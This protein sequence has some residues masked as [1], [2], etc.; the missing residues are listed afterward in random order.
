MAS[1]FRHRPKRISR[2]HERDR[3]AAWLVPLSYLAAAVGT[4]LAVWGAVHYSVA[5]EV[6]VLLVALSATLLIFPGGVL[7][8][9]W[10]RGHY[11]NRL[12]EP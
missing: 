7:L 2:R 9:R 5:G 6:P 8:F 3:T 12:D 4:G 1:R 10:V 11:D